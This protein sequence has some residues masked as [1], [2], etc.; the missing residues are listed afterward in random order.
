MTI[1]ERITALVGPPSPATAAMLADDKSATAAA[2]R[3]LEAIQ[4]G[5]S[6]RPRR[7]PAPRIE[8]ISKAA[9]RKRVL[10]LLGPLSLVEQAMLEDPKSALAAAVRKLEEM[11][12]GRYG[13]RAAV[14]DALR[15]S[16]VQGLRPLFRK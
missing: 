3:D 1:Q 4:Y 7:K 8:V 2:V 12:Y 13:R 10:Q 15:E 9:I 5:R 14:T 6:A 16:A 11:M